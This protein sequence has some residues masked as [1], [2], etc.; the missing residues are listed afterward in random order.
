VRVYFT[1]MPLATADY[2][3]LMKG[4]CVMFSFP[5]RRRSAWADLSHFSSVALD[6]GAYSVWRRGVEVDIG[7]YADYC[8]RLA[9]ALEWYANLDVIG[10]WRAGLRNLFALERRALSPVPVFHLGEPWGL[11]ED[12]V[13]AYPRVALA[14][15]AGITLRR[16]RR[17]LDEIFSRFS[18]ADGAPMVRFHGFRMTD[19]RMMARFPFESVDSTTWIA[20]SAWDALPT[21]GG[22]ASGFSFLSD[23]QKAR[24]WLSFFD[25]IPKASRFT[26]PQGGLQ[27]SLT[28]APMRSDYASRQHAKRYLP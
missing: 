7:E 10:D 28:M 1:G 9:D 4:R 21:D 23:A 19:R 22:R 15:G 25:A 16:T 5:Y 27:E 6:S 14:R 17:M 24:I 13:C 3:S 26:N 2:L 8:A 11:L 18:D 20:G 12:F